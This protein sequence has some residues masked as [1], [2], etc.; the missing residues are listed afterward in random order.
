MKKYMRVKNYNEKILIQLKEIMPYE[1]KKTA[2]EFRNIEQWIKKEVYPTYNQLIRVANIF[3]IPF[4]YFFLDK[5]PEKKFPIPHYRTVEK[6]DYQ[7]FVPSRELI[8]TVEYVELLQEWAKDILI[9]WG[10][11]PLS[12]I[13]KYNIRS[14]INNVNDELRNILRLK[15][16]WAESIETW[17]DAF[18]LLIQRA[19]D[20]GIFVVVNGIVGNNTQRKLD[21]NEFR[22]F[23]LCDK[24][25][26]FIFINNQDA[27]SAK[28]FTLIHE[29]VHLLIG[30]SASFDLRNLQSADN[31]IEKFCDKCTADFLVPTSEIKQIKEV[32][33][34]R[35]ARQFKVSQ[36]VIARRLLDINKINKNQF[37]TFYNDYIQKEHIKTESKGGD[38]YRTAI[39]RYGRKFIELVSLG[40]EAGSIFYRDA[41]HLTRLKPTTFD[42]LKQ[43]VL[44][45]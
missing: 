13:G 44:S 43:E 4:G 12:F 45:N 28:I 40:V 37:L 42:R 25:A 29:I 38:F 31:E 3:R 24:I 27:I 20:A 16:N 15:D 36:I 33:F 26:P 22:G 5:L 14:N 23:V 19:E 8:E 34:D 9:D 32:D 39:R 41:Y 1:W 35:L 6:M 2:L 10:H 21:V 11:E 30:K 7:H 18:N 17:N